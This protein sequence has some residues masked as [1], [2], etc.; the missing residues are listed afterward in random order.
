MIN[1]EYTQPQRIEEIHRKE[2]KEHKYDRKESQAIERM[3]KTV[4]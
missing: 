4:R 1:T 2:I 3:L